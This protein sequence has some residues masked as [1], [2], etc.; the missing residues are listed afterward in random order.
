MNDKKKTSLDF[1]D[2]AD[3]DISSSDAAIE[4]ERTATFFMIARELSNYLN[5]LPLTA[6][7]HNKLIE[8]IIDQVQAAE[9]GAFTQGVKIGAEYGKQEMKG[10]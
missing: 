8:L 4:V 6:E 7:A 5:T 9:A 3:L 1:E 10:T 2:F